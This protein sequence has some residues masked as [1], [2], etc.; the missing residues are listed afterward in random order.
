MKAAVYAR[1]S[2]DNQR[3]ASIE[4]QVRQCAQ[5]IARRGWEQV[6]VFSD[7]EMSGVTATR[8]VGYQAMLRSAKERKFDVLVVDELSR[9]TRDPEELAGLRKRF[10]FWGVGLVAL[11]DGLDTI[12]APGA[13]APIMAIKGIIN[14]AEREANAYRSRRGLAGRVLA[15]QH[16]GGAP[17]GYRTKP[18]HAD[19]PGD[20]PGTGPIVGHAYIVHEAEAAAIR[21]I[22]RLFADGMSPRKIAALL[23]R[24][25][26]P[27]PAARW[28][29]RT[30]VRRS[31]S[32][33]SIYGDAKKHTGLLNQ[34]KYIG[35][36]VWNRS[37][38][39]GDPDRDGKQVR[40]E[41]PRERWV[42]QDVP[43]LRILPQDLWDKVKARQ[44]AAGRDVRKLH[45]HQRNQRLLSGL[46][47]CG[48][49]GGKL[50]LRGVRTYGCASRQNR[51]TAICDSL[52]TVNADEAQ[53][54][55]LDAIEQVLYSEKMLAE[56]A[57]RV[58]QKV[59]DAKGRAGQEQRDDA[60]L[61]AELAKVDA[62]IQR[63]VDG[64]AAGV[65]VEELT[66]K[67]KQ[68]EAKRN[69]LRAELA[70]AEKHNCA[71]TLDAIP[72][73]VRAYVGDL[74]LLIEHGQLE[75]VKR[76]LAHLVS[77]A[78]VE[79][80]PV[81]GRKR[82][83]ARLILRGNLQGVL[84]LTREKSRLVVAPAGFEPAISWLRTMHPRPLD[85]GATPHFIWRERRKW[86]GER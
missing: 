65:L 80:V 17:Y 69:R 85:D 51:G 23:N 43:S 84:E 81:P 3:P 74:R 7:A 59:A 12:Q 63:L 8:R 77:R 30:G 37:T 45:S 79:E 20:P 48:K 62:E 44:E 40:R 70:G 66:Q 54:T 5:E 71:P 18:V 33:S 60:G 28:R 35:R 16:A 21:R 42:I 13:A 53:Q 2:S 24:E 41:M 86:K 32:F 39:P 1:Y 58:R 9:I 47:T 56:I 49:C 82:P 57:N 26:V 83:G 25:G 55:I 19:K 46:L 36:L 6:E 22:F 10:S 61:R 73:M 50:V 38:W 78:D 67:A 72:A 11:G 34:E 68:A 75:R 15:G 4:D 64:I 29:N 14:E 31:W 76:A 52:V 27:C